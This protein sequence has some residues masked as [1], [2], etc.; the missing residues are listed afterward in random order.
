MSLRRQIKYKYQYGVNFLRSLHLPAWAVGMRARVILT[1]LV[2]V[3]GVAY[4]GQTSSL[5][6][7]GYEIQHLEHRITVLNNDLQRLSTEV[8]AAQ[9]MTSIQK[10]LPT[11]QMVAV[12]D[13][14]YL[15][16]NSEVA[17][18]KR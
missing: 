2:L 10:R 9:S 18:A 3:L 15:K 7:S 12:T 5:S 16:I 4:I 8:A 13:V 1:L 11:I 17:V 14:K 6:T